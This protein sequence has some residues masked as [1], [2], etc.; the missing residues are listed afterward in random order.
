MRASAS[1]APLGEKNVKAGYLFHGEEMFPAREFIDRLRAALV[2]PEGE[3]A[4]EDHYDLQDAEWRDIVDAARHV[5]FFFSPWRLIIVEASKAG[6]ADLDK[7]EESVLRGFF[8]DPTPKTVLLVLYAG[9]L[10]KTKPLYKLFDGLPESVAEIEELKPLKDIR[11]TTWADRKTAS[12]GK[13]ISSDA[14]ERLFE[15]AGNDLRVLDSE[16]EKLA[17]YIG[18]KKLI[19]ISDVHA[20]S[21]WVKDFAS[22]ELTDPLEKGDIARALLV[23][24]RMMADGVRGEM[25]LGILAG[26][27]RDLFRGRVALRQG[28]D[29]R[30]FFRELRP[31]IL[32][33]YPFYRAQFEAFY[34]AVEGM[35]AHEFARL[36]AELERLDLKIKTTDSDPQALFEAFFYEFGRALRRPDVTSKKR[37]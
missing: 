32:P 37:G 3:A 22:Y 14:L 33:Q 24:N 15:T 18:D 13:R 1:S 29:K 27:L 12:L 28:R 5:P 4:A 11:L 30:E 31:R 2:T 35:P 16:L 20:A 10:G 8:A 34:G 21:D 19:E 6:Q 17:T 25:V 36:T 9:K 26:F 23:L 7:D